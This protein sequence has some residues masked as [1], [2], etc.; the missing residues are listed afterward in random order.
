MK[1]AKQDGRQVLL[2]ARPIRI[3]AI[4]STL[5]RKKVHGQPGADHGTIK[6]A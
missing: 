5:A 3:A 4:I 2:I 6:P 1:P